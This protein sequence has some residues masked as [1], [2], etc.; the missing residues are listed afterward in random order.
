MFHA[1]L[2]HHQGVIESSLGLLHL[3]LINRPSVPHI[4]IVPSVISRGAPH[5]AAREV[6][7]SE[8]RKLHT[9][10]FPSAHNKLH[11]M[12]SFTCPQSWNMGQII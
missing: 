6:S 11:L 12:G 1:L 7:V 2:T 5:H 9:R 3:G 8:G 4:Q 10:I